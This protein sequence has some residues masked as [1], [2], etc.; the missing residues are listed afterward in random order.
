MPASPWSRSLERGP[1]RRRW[2]A[3]AAL[4]LVLAVTGSS[5]TALA[6]VQETPFP[7]DSPDYGPG[8]DGRVNAV[9]RLGNRVYIGGDFTS[10]GGENRSYLAAV[11][12]T[13]GELDAT[14]APVASG[15]VDAIEVAPDGSVIYVGGRFNNVNG[16]TRHRVAALD[17]VTG[18]V[19]AWNPDAGAK[20]RAIAAT[21][22]LV[23][24][25]G[26]FLTV[27]GEDAAYL[28]AVNTTTGDV[29]PG[30][31][32]QANDYVFDLEASADQDT[33]VVAGRFTN[34]GGLSRPRLARVDAADGDVSSWRPVPP[35]VV[36]DSA[37]S[38][39]ES[40]VYAAIG[41]PGNGGGNMG[42]AYSATSGNQLW[43]HTG[44]GDFQ[45]VAVS[46]DS[47]YFGGHFG[48]IEGS[49]RPRIAAFNSATGTLRGWNPG[50][51]SGL[52]VW[53]LRYDQNRLL[54]GGDFSTVNG[55]TQ[56]HFAMLREPN[57]SPPVASFSSDCGVL[58]CEF[59]AS[60]SF[61]P[62]GSVT[63]YLWD[64][65]D[66]TSAGGVSPTHDYSNA[67]HFT[68]TLTVTDDSGGIDEKVA[69][70]TNG[71]G[72]TLVAFRKAVS[73]AKRGKG[74]VVTVPAGVAGGDALLLFASVAPGDA[75]FDGPSGGVTGW[76]ALGTRKAGNVKTRLWA[77][78]AAPGDAGDKVRVQFDSTE[79]IS[80]VLVA[81]SGT[82]TSQPVLAWSKAGKAT[83]TSAHVTPSVTASVNHGWLVSYWAN[84]SGGTTTWTVP[85][86]DTARAA[87]KG[88]SSLHV[89]AALSDGATAYPM[90][91]FGSKTAIADDDGPATTWSIALAPRSNE[92][93]VAA[94]KKT[95]SALACDV[96][97]KNSFDPDGAIV[98]YRWVFGDGTVLFG[99]KASHEYDDP[100]TYKIKLV[101]KDDDG[102][103]ATTK[104]TVT[105]P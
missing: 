4:T 102:A 1:G 59:D 22:D 68:V 25:G 5:G 87:T 14:W 64:F 94:F 79:D 99:E 97:A 7:T 12:R 31:N 86:G 89:T 21:D 35:Y 13:T 78:V 23:V 48:S 17:P 43:S 88:P 18:T 76:E 44:N 38:P 85:G 101:V 80:L 46:D 98:S 65:G 49:T 57:S 66:G 11:N 95:C 63:G 45:A 77:T 6:V 37:L 24:I 103:K 75:A 53:A 9:A 70:I 36:I 2:P 10:V 96:D 40:V 51:N 90:G 54:V 41:G 27:G 93:P 84:V 74:A 69:E 34:L 29:V 91:T 82:D 56:P 8:P 39:D 15:I 83:P 71:T 28:A 92:L 58:S 42:A 50:M 62:D 81:Y 55:T 104:R 47:V 52:G 19:T 60:A 3:A 105:V 33:V 32:T 30:W 73:T 26:N 72:S 20:V 61:D 67:G 16:V 100:G